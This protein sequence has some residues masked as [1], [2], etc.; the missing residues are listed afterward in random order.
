MYTML[1]MLFLTRFPHGILHPRFDARMVNVTA[2]CCSRGKCA[3]VPRYCTYTCSKVRPPR[4]SPSM[5]ACARVQ[6]CIAPRA[7]WRHDSGVFVQV[8]PT[9]FSECRHLIDMMAPKPIPGCADAS[10]AQLSLQTKGR[11]A[12]C[13]G[14][15]MAHLCEVDPSEAEV[16]CPV[17]C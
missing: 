5:D 2:A 8:L 13:A 17:P 16:L 7:T 3:T 1:C 10:D 11:F 4:D 15:K 12:D 9:F 14:A 6:D